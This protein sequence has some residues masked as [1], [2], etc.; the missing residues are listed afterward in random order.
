[1]SEFAGP[2][3]DTA[4]FYNAIGVAAVGIVGGKYHRILVNAV[5]LDTDSPRHVATMILFNQREGEPAR[6]TAIGTDTDTLQTAI[7][8]LQDHLAETGQAPWTRMDYVLTGTKMA[9]D[10]FYPDQFDPATL[11]MMA[12]SAELKAKHFPEAKPGLLG[13]LFG[14]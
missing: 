4:D 13:R 1:M 9:V 6:S 2:S 10:L 5:V 12:L 7:R 3:A 14:R 8:G 11:D